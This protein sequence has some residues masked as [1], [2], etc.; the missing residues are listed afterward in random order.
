MPAFLLEIGL[1]EIPA[2]MIAAAQ[3]ELAQRVEKLLTRERLTTDAL[4]VTSYS[5][6]RRLAVLVEGRCPSSRIC[7]KTLLGQRPKLRTRMAQPRRRQSRLPRNP[8]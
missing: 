3:A 4:R 7:R 2:G 6:P 5:T 1:E 8:V